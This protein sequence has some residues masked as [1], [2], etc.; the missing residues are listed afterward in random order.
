MRKKDTSAQLGRSI[1]NNEVKKPKYTGKSKNFD[2]GKVDFPQLRAKVD[3]AVISLRTSCA[4]SSVHSSV[5]EF[6]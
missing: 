4:V 1:E 2:V 6:P 3:K 5:G